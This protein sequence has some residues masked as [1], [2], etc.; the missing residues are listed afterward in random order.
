MKRIIG[1]LFLFLLSFT[2][3][4]A[5]PGNTAADGCHYCRTNCD[6]WGVPWNE[7]HCHGGTTIPVVTAKPTVKATPIP[8]RIYT[9][10]PIKL[11][12]PT[13]TKKPTVTPTLKVTLA[14]IQKVTPTATPTEQ[15]TI[16]PTPTT[17]VLVSPTQTVTPTVLAIK[18]TQTTGFWGWLSRFFG[19]K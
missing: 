19:G 6:K 7:R 10:A 13:Q 1:S 2:P 14:P 9:P 15:I 16:T 12:T 3:V 5:H 11:S 17:E 8:T 18:T 4:M